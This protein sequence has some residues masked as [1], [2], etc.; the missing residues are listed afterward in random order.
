MGGCNVIDTGV[1]IDDYWSLSHFL[2][3]FYITLYGMRPDHVLLLVYI[4]ETIESS[5]I[6]ISPNFD[7]NWGEVESLADAVIIDAFAGLIGIIVALVIRFDGYG[8]ERETIPN[9]SK[10]IILLHVLSNFFLFGEKED[11]TYFMFIV[12]NGI[13]SLFSLY[14]FKDIGTFILSNVYLSAMFIVVTIADYN[15]FLLGI[16]VSIAVCV[17][18][19]IHGISKI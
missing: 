14:T 5:I 19:I 15:T 3:P 12:Y 17:T 4:W 2:L 1:Y 18:G 13:I 16:Y 7:S 10:L 11:V 9:V 8:L 6:C